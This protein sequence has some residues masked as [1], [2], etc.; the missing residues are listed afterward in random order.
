MQNTFVLMEYRRLLSWVATHL[1]YGSLIYANIFRA[2]PLNKIDVTRFVLGK[3]M[4][5]T[6][7][8]ITKQLIDEWR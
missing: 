5:L 4:G 1:H 2:D 6:P 8:R 7:N 3:D